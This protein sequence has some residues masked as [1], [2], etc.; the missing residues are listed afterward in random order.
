MRIEVTEDLIALGKTCLCDACPVALAINNV[1]REG[2]TSKV[3][4]LL[5]SIMRGNITHTQHTMPDSVTAFVSNFDRC[6]KVEPF[7]FDLAISRA[8]LR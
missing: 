6:R 5:I 8:A 7:T 3:S 1:L 2:Y 4:A